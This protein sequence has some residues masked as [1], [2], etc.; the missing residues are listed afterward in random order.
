MIILPDNE[1]E[2]MIIEEDLDRTI[3]DILEYIL[4]QIERTSFQQVSD[5]RGT[6]RSRNVSFV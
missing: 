6:D 4:Q 5:L 2:Q 1:I 3:E